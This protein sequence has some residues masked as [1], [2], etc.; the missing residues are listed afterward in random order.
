[1]NAEADKSSPSYSETGLDDKA[2]SEVRLLLAKLSASDEIAGVEGRINRLRTL[3]DSLLEPEEFRVGDIVVW[4]NG[5]KN[6]AY[7][8]YGVPAIVVEVL[9]PP[10]LDPTTDSGSVYFRE[11]LNL[12]LGIADEGG[13]FI[14]F[15]YD[16]RRFEHYRNPG[17]RLRQIFEKHGGEIVDT[18]EEA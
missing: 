16:G 18:K 12:R 10:L 2:M 5:L 3:L 11:P 9:N 6:R 17:D 4:R 1:M 13:D 8:D 7:P 15:L 14:T